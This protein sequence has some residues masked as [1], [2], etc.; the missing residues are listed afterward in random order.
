TLPLCGGEGTGSF[1]TPHPC[2]LPLPLLGAASYVQGL[3][4]Y[5]ARLFAAQEGDRVRDVLRLA[6]PL[7]RH[8]R[9]RTQ[10]ERLEVDPHPL[11]R[12]SR[13]PSLHEPRRDRIHV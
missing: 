3:A 1:S 7:Q 13:H 11:R 2:P 12:L 9:G 5:V 8:L 6:D 10:L 4:A